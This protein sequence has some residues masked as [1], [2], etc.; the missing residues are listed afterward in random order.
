MNTLR[1]GTPALGAPGSIARELAE[2]Q[3]MLK[4]MANK[5]YIC[6]RLL[7]AA[8]ERCGWDSREVQELV[9]ALRASITE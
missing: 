8:A 1:N 7:T 4:G 3:D 5:L 2:A 6:S 9:E